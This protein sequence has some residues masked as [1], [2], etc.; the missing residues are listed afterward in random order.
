MI[1]R[2]KILLKSYKTEIDPSLEQITKINQTIGTCRFVYNLFISENEKAYKEGKKY[3]NNYEFSKWLNNK[4]IPN[5]NDYK[6]I[7]DIS[8]KSVRNSIDNANIAFMN[9]F[10]S[11]KKP[12]KKLTDKQ[13]KKLEKKSKKSIINNF[14]KFKKKNKNES[15]MYFV[16][17]NKNAI[18]KCERHRTKVPT[19]GWVKLKE[20]GYLPTNLIIK[21]GNI[22]KKAGRYYISVVVETEN[23]NKFHEFN[24]GIGIDLGIKN[25]AICSNKDVYKNINKTE[26]VRKL[27]KKLKRE[28]RSLS[29]KIEDKKGRKEESTQNIRKNILR[30]QKLNQRLDNIRTDYINKVINEIVKAKPSYITIED[31]NISGIMNNKYLSKAIASQKLYE[32]RSKL[33]NKCKIHGIELRIANRYYASSKICHNCGNIKKN[34]LLKDRIYKCNECGMILDRDY[35]ASLN[36]RDAK[37]Y[38]II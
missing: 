6:W 9:F 8:S 7:K 19:L 26:I 10:K 34:L 5:N 24:E 36:L 16:R 28:Q 12:K 15:S 17:T 2:T 22:T 18:I 13:K 1:R 4:F 35:N 27:D 37:E 11:L 21:H 23:K 31:L 14:P 29:R 25:L 38:S 20:K 30:I 33:T 32:F 3:I